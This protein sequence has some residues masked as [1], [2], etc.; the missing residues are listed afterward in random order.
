MAAVAIHIYFAMMGSHGLP[1]TNSP[2]LLQPLLWCEV[3]PNTKLFIQ[4]V[5]VYG[6]DR[7]YLE[8][9][10]Y[11]FYY[12]NS[13]AIQTTPGV[14]VPI[15]SSQCP[16]KVPPGVH[17]C[18][19]LRPLIVSVAIYLILSY[20]CLEHCNL[21][22]TPTSYSEIVAYY[23]N[24]ISEGNASFRKNYLFLIGE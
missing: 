10:V 16:K 5:L 17:L 19:F 7:S 21:D 12:S 18:T 14:A 22:T 24:L 13:F 4:R 2:P 3:V 23:S 11:T 9:S 8:E 20:L 1:W 15:P 6:Q